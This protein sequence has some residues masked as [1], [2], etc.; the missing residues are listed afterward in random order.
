MTEDAG[1]PP[2]AAARLDGLLLDAKLSIPALRAGAVSRRELVDTAR[3]SGR[4]VVG[5]TAPAGY[6]KSTLLAQWAHA[7]DR[8]VAWVTLDRFDD[9]PAALLTLLAAAFT[10][11][12]PGHPD[13]MADVGGV[14]VS[15]LGRGAPRLASAFRTAPAP[16][17]LMLDD[18]HELR[19]AGCHDVLGVVISGIPE[20]SQ[21][22]A[23][24]RSAQPHLPRL[25]ASGGVLEFVAPDLALDAA[26]AAQIFSQ[27]DVSI[28]SEVA[29]AVAERTEGWPVGLYLAAVIAGDS[30]GEAPAISG[31]DRYVADYLYR[32][33]LAQLPEATQEF[34]RCT[35]VLDQ[36]CA[37]LCDA[38][39]G[40][41]DAQDLL[42]RLEASN[43]FLVPLDRR[44]EWYRYHALFREFLL[45]ELRRVEPDTVEKLHLRAADWY[46]SN[47]S[48]ALALE[49]LLHT[50]DRDRC[51][52]LVTALALPT[53]QA[54]QL[55]TLQ[56]WLA[57]LGDAA[58][59][60]YPPL[61]VLAGWI[62][63][64]TGRIG[65]AQRWAAILEDASF[66]LVPMDGS[67]SF[68]S[69]RAM[70]RAIM[71][72]SGPE[73]LMADASFAA[74]EEPAWSVWRDQALHLLGAAHHLAGDGARAGVLYALSADLAAERAN[75]DVLVISA[76]E[77]ALLEMEGGRWAAAAEHVDRALD[78]IERHRLHDY[79]TCLL[80][81]AAAAG[82]AVHR[83]D[84]DEA[85]RLLTLAMRARPTCTYALPFVAVRLR[86][87]L[88]KVYWSLADHT[89]ARHLLREVDDV[90]VH[91]PALGTLVD[92]V[93]EFRR[94]ITAGG[95]TVRTG[96][97]P[98]TPAELRLLPYLQT[99][100]K[101]S[102]IAERLYVSR[103]TVSTQIGSIYRKL[104]VSSRNE[105][106]EHATAVGLL[107]G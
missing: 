38:V 26:G 17:V 86:L 45:A 70:L 85:N 51:V 48:P 53:Y 44:R 104:G 89:T 10:R 32:E 12:S 66:D 11:V 59:E 91:R 29:A 62:A 71:C 21:L 20:G 15:V 27:A 5:V 94:Q 105:A 106:V 67:A 80:A 98:L 78:A 73:Q 92:D 7:E 102:E 25:R 40:G 76:S 8:P 16:F 28:T 24:S 30:R 100:L 22:V 63:A 84:M 34:L 18:L 97:S 33:S 77:A 65:D 81:F 39:L 9:D 52:Q 23:A 3:G 46:E 64:L 83:G 69:A 57:A 60:A 99:H 14:G 2:T 37:P 79:A 42:R 55:S 36:M 88:A 49:H 13:L 58:I 93:A 56:R 4:R 82:L 19:S 54:G 90:L 68:A 61:A 47:G 75:A 72:A 31:D 74:A 1:G 41:S 6:G 35:A 101:F 87:Q 43:S 96:R 103:N 95:G 107:G 50:G